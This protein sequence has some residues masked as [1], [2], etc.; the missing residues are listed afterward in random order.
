MKKLNL[1]LMV[2]L[3]I[4]Q[5]SQAQ[6]D[7][8]LWLEEVD[9]KVAL[10]FVETQ[11][12]ATIEEL[13]AEK[14]F[15]DIYDKSLAIY[16]STER[17]AYP[18]IL[19]N[20]VYNFW[21]DKDHVRGVWRRSLLKDY[22]N[23]NPVWETLL[24]IDALSE[25]D[26]I[27]WVY[28][29]SS[30]LYPDYNRFLVRLSKGGGDAVVTKEFDVNSKQFLEYGFKV[31]ESKGSS[32][33]VDENT[34]IITTDF[35]KG[36]LTTSGYPRQVKLWKRGTPLKDAQQ[37][38]EGDTTNVQVFGYVLRDGSK[39]YTM[40]RQ[41]IDFYTGKTFVW[42]NNKAIA[43]DIPEDASTNGILNNQLILKLKS[44]WTVNTKTYKTGTLI[45]LNFTELLKGNKDIQV[46]IEPDEFSSISRVST[47]KNKLLIDL[48]SNVTSQLYIYSFNNGTWSN[49]KVKAPDFGTISIV[50]TND[51]SDKYFFNFQN[52]ITPSTLYSADASNNTFKAY[53]SLPAFFDAS[54]YEIKQYKAKSKDG[55]M[56]PYFMV[57]AKDIKNDGTNPTLV[58]AYGGFEVSS[59][60][61][62]GATF[63]VSWLD[64]GGVFVLANIRGG[65]EFGPKWHQDGVKEKR[66]NVFD[67]LYAVSEDLITKKVTAPKHLGVMGGSNGGL[68]VGVAFT[69]RPDLYNAIVC[70]VPLL[71]MKRYNKLL[72]GASWMGEYGNPDLP[73]EW[74]YIK[75]YSPYQNLKEGMNYPEVY[76][77][78]STRDDRVHPGHARKMVAKMNDMG[79]KTYYYE[80]TEGGHAGSSTNEQSAKSDALTFSY[81]LMKLK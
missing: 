52:F 80:N 62:Y 46:I 43:L 48:L 35:G 58:F 67:D 74:E 81:L 44:D 79:Y 17:I 77:G 38:F 31:D 75:K 41:S 15:Q 65:G 49:E 30:G 39:A 60:P 10:E 33:Y 54:K 22:T 61:F 25:A 2:I 21:R 6:E 1:V 12:K 37:I 56:I 68:L 32:S 19:G 11:N 78:T 66:Q 42:R 8:Y 59:R 55:T 13:G 40:V 71:D 34:L 24:D 57:A 70:Q 47:T 28:K 76:F 36:T 73:E 18:S 9:G 64:K 20:Y 51:L 3:G 45:S 26:D 7:K 16:N 72:A 23:G 63:G 29:G 50:S 53:Q 14:D 5:I 4:S 27:K 69:Q